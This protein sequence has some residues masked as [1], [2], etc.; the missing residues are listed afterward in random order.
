MLTTNFIVRYK[1]VIV[2]TEPLTYSEYGTSV[3]IAMKTQ[4]MRMTNITVILKHLCNTKDNP[5]QL[6]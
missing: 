4:L 3:L 6:L 5:L 1:T 2:V